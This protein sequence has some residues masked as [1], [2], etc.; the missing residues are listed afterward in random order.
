[1]ARTDDR[2]AGRR[3][4]RRPA[5]LLALGLVSSLG[6]AGA[7][8]AVGMSRSAS[9]PG[10]PL[11]VRISPESRTISPG[12]TATY[13]VNVDRSDPRSIGLS[14]R[15]N[16]TIGDRG[17]PAGTDASFTSAALS[18]N[19]GPRAR[20]ILRITTRTDT[21]PGTYKVRLRADRPS[22][23][24]RAT[25][26]LTVSPP[27]IS[28]LPA[29]EPSPSA[30]P[31][32]SPPVIPPGTPVIAPDAFTIAGVLP[33]RLI[34]GSGGA[35]DLTLTNL[36]SSDLLITSLDVEVAAVNGPRADATHTCEPDDFA[37]EQFSGAPGFTLPASATLDLDQLG[38]E[39]SE[40]PRISMLNLPSNQDGCKGASLSLSFSGTATEAAP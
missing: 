23:S 33:E 10:R 2:R 4:G 1:M 18:A 16:L 13:L 3:L 20:T 31:P 38:F 6:A 27:P 28:G 17:L 8:A 22:R 30:E 12:S 26:E 37:V 21:P 40:W 35:L 36:E 19:L 5:L 25:V 32:P 9:S 34:P 11:I 29:P 39:P 15:T 24:G 14:G 7:F